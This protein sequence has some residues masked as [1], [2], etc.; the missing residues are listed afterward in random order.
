MSIFLC[1]VLCPLY[2]FQGLINNDRGM[3]YNTATNEEIPIDQAL[4]QG[5]IVG[6]LVTATGQQEI[7]RSA[8]VA[9]RISTDTALVSVINPIT[10]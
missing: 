2:K 6:Q 9:S 10:G 7:F 8:H 4:D 5:M 1:V 3:F